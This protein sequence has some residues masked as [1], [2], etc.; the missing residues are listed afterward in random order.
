MNS[1]GK[2]R[3]RDVAVF[4]PTYSSLLSDSGVNMT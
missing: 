4:Y 2:R 3:N 1:I